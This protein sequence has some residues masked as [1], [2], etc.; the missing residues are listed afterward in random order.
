MC[1]CVRYFFTCFHVRRFAHLPEIQPEK[2]EFNHNIDFIKFIYL[3]TQERAFWMCCHGQCYRFVRFA[4]AAVC[5]KSG[6]RCT[7]FFFFLRYFVLVSVLFGP[8]W[9]SFSSWFA[10][11]T[12]KNCTLWVET[13][14][15]MKK[16]AKEETFNQSARCETPN[17]YSVA[18]SN[19]LQCVT[20][21][22]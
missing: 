13:E 21:L 3:R 22:I 7:N 16:S 19:R 1:V 8:W 10:L 5:E 4:A 15:K 11:K 12:H 20:T 18:A 17:T 14:R 6:L 2:M 9:K